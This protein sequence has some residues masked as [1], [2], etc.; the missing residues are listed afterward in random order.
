MEYAETKQASGHDLLIVSALLIDKSK[1]LNLYLG[2]FFP[3]SGILSKNNPGKE[4]YLL[5]LDPLKANLNIESYNSV[6]YA[7]TP[8]THTPKFD[9]QALYSTFKAFSL[10]PFPLLHDLHVSSPRTEFT[11]VERS[12]APVV[13]S[14]ATDLLLL[15]RASVDCL[16][17][18]QYTPIGT[19]RPCWYL[20]QVNLDN[21]ELRPFLILPLQ[22][23][24][25]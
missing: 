1:G 3:K 10:P 17:F 25:P 22:A 13:S 6:W 12:D 20:V 24:I 4:D 14:T 15:L 5:M 7:T 2:L 9:Y 23:C 16:C 18:I 19:L 8:C 21:T 11:P